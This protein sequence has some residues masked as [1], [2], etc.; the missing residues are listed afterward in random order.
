[1]SGLPG[2]TFDCFPT[3]GP[4]T[5]RV[6]RTGTLLSFAGRDRASPGERWAASVAFP[7]AFV[8]LSDME[9]LSGYAEMR[10]RV[11]QNSGKLTEA[12]AEFSMMLGPSARRAATAKAMAM[13]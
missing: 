1:M 3:S 8:S 11:A 13:R 2:A 6:F 7:C 4:R 5:G 10:A 9:F 12:A